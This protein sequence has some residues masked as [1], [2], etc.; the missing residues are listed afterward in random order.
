MAETPASGESR[1]VPAGRRASPQA[2]VRT[3]ASAAV[4]GKAKEQEHG[5]AAQSEHGGGSGSRGKEKLTA[6]DADQEH[7]EGRRPKARG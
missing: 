2:T 3:G 5:Q 4:R 1:Q 6:A 7:R